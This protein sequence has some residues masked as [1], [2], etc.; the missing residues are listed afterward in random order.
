MCKITSNILHCCAI[1]YD[2]SALKY[3]FNHEEH[4]YVC[5]SLMGI[6]FMPQSPESDA[7][8]LHLDPFT[9]NVKL[10]LSIS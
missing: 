9:V 6:F 1:F 8:F 3:V 10:V 5:L 2:L 4:P 7:P